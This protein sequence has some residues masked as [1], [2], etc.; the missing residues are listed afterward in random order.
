MAR[1]ALLG[2]LRWCVPSV[3][4]SP[5]CVQAVESKQVAEQDA[6]RA[7]FVVLKA[8]QVRVAM[9]RISASTT[10]SYGATWLGI[11]AGARQVSA[12]PSISRSVAWSETVPQNGILF[13]CNLPPP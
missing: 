5:V 4:V 11:S 9:R 1:C 8:E 6:E 2:L 12:E 10:C 7:R 13:T 3:C